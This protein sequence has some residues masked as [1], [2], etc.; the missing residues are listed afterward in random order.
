VAIRQLRVETCYIPPTRCSSRPGEIPEGWR[1]IGRSRARTGP[2]GCRRVGG[3]SREGAPIRPPW[4]WRLVGGER[5]RF[6]NRHARAFGRQLALWGRGSWW[7]VPAQAGRREHTRGRGRTGRV[8]T[9]GRGGGMASVRC[10]TV[11]SATWRR[12]R[13][14][15]ATPS[16]RRKPRRGGELTPR[17]WF[18]PCRVQAG[19]GLPAA[20]GLPVP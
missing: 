16:T 10:A 17:R 7:S 15:F 12:C 18:I 9:R 13:R 6:N 14:D 5:D 1:L 20:R 2:S 4:A 11:V 8:K 19:G 3:T